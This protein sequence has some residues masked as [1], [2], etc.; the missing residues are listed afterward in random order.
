MRTLIQ[1][2]R[3]GFR[4][5]MRSPGFTLIAVLTLAVGIA[6][7][8]TVFSWIDAV[9]VHPLPGVN[10]EGLV[11][12]EGVAPNGE[13]LTNSWLDYRDYRDHLK[14]LSGLAVGRPAA[15]SL[16]DDERSERVTGELVSGNYFAV[17]DVKPIAGRVFTREEYGDKQGGYPVAVI[18]ERLWNRKYRSDPGVVGSTIRLNRQ[19]LTVVGVVPG[20]FRGS[21]P[22]LTFEIWAP[23]TMATALN[24][25]PDWMLNDR[26]SR[27]FISCLGRL[28]PGVTIEQAR[29]ETAAVAK[30]VAKLD[31]KT[32]DLS[33]TLFPV[34][35][36]HIG[37]QALLLAPLT[38][39][40]AVG[41]VVLLIVCANVAN[42]LLSRS[43]ARQKELSMRMALG[44][45]RGRLVQQLM[46]ETLAL[47]LMGAAVAIPLTMWLSHS[48]AYLVPPSSMPVFLDIRLSGD[49]LA[50]MTL[51]CIGA[52]LV[53]GVA[54]A[55][56]TA[57]ASLNEVLKDSGR[58]GSAGA[59]SRLRGV[60]VVSEVALALVVLIGAALFARSFQMARQINPGFDANHVLTSRLYLATAGYSAPDRKL[61]CQRLR[62]RLESQP[63]IESVSYADLVP[64][65]F[66]TSWEDLQIEGYVPHRGESMKLYRNVVAPGYFNVLHIPVLEGRDFTEQDDLGKTPAMIVTQTFAHRF[67]G[68]R[69]AIGHKVHG[70]GQWFTIVG[71]VRDS[72]YS[73]PNEAPRPHFYVAFR[74]VYRADLDI[75]FF[76]RTMGDPLEALPLMREQVKQM[77]PAVG[78]YDAMPMAES[79]QA[80]LFGLRI[81]ASLLAALGTIALVLAAVGLY[82]VM[83]YSVSQRTQEIG[84]RMALGARPRDVLAMTV[85]QGMRI[86]LIGLAAGVVAALAVTRVVAGVLVHVSATDPL[87]FI[88]A[89]AF[90]ALVALAASYIPARRA[91]R[92]D[93]NVALRC[94]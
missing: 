40:M 13:Y 61:F 71:V 53:A 18:S 22:G 39:L 75:A 62:E 27:V 90:L 3:Y 56:H 88:G 30:E 80:A 60:L 67:F 79:V 64:L 25:M 10:N 78:V 42:L 12:L 21:I 86:T 65:S 41:A 45:G 17:L 24:A 19:N 87:V 50:F 32:K 37:A 6:A 9:L 14:L 38:I 94:Q 7:N 15:F 54:P 68:D 35:K 59:G 66:N 52:C 23:A 63:G 77:D 2:L 49:V 69:P 92:I 91:T 84:I 26:G 5:A 44:A 4:M 46:T 8:T 70:W 31:T 36:G 1:D 85:G 76:V 28:K 48:L 74:Q 43:T 33:A 89:A 34:W 57:N 73:E 11:T 20:S 72:K 16:G 93:P 29:A 81:A 58:T 82:G 83:A 51:V 55:W 47:A